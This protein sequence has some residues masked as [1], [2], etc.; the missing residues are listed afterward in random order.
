MRRRACNRLRAGSSSYGSLNRSLR[1]ADALSGRREVAFRWTVTRRVSGPVET[2]GL[3]GSKGV[4]GKSMMA[5]ATLDY[6]LAKVLLVEYDNA[7]PNVCCTPSGLLSAKQTAGFVSSTYATS[8]AIAQSSR[9]PPR[10][11]TSP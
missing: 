6:L 11:T 5:L 4:V 8:T 2:T 10:T 3:A 7:N 9:T 1:G